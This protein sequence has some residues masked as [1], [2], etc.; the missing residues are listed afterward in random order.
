L[1]IPG[2][3]GGTESRQDIA[4]NALDEIIPIRLG[5]LEDEFLDTGVAEAAD[6]I[7]KGIFRVPRVL[8]A[9][10]SDDVKKGARDLR[11]F[12]LFFGA[13]IIQHVV[14]LADLVDGTAGIPGIGEA[15]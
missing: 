8:V 13:G 4:G 6:E 12:S 2:V 3:S 11:W 1:S 9:H 10:M 7:G 14:A 15:G 5:R